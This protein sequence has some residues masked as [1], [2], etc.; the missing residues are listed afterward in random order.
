[1]KKEA[2]MDKYTDDD[3]PIHP[4]T[5]CRKCG[6]T[7]RCKCSSRINCYK[8]TEYVDECY[9]CKGKNAM[10]IKVTSLGDDLYKVNDED[11]PIDKQELE[12]IVKDERHRLDNFWKDLEEKKQASLELKAD[13]GLVV[14]MFEVEYPQGQGSE[15]EVL[16][17]LDRKKDLVNE[18]V[19]P[20]TTIPDINVS[21]KR[22]GRKNWRQVLQVKSWDTS[23]TTYKLSY[24]KTYDSRKSDT[25]RFPNSPYYNVVY[26]LMAG[27]VKVG[28]YS[29]D[30]TSG[31]IKRSLS[32]D[33]DGLK[34]LF[35][36][37][38]Q[39]SWSSGRGDITH[40]RGLI[41]HVN[42][43]EWARELNQLSEFLGSDK[44]FE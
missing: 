21:V 22:E 34:Q 44:H 37:D 33:S 8:P 36:K 17:N 25:R 30:K 10:L 11:T 4:I 24:V 7:T 26:S 31:R 14:D 13:T 27:D 18:M 2:D 35:G 1:M 43:S 9:N 19:L 28:D 16:Q 40:A 12:G 3:R 38:V 39:V 6:N 23:V 41:R 32:W 42:A 15:E 20:D 29:I 5:I